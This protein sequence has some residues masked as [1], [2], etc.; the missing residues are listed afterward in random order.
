MKK[1]FTI[2]EILI[3]MMI[4]FISITFIN[5]SIQTFNNYQKK[6]KKYQNFYVTALSLKDWISEQPLD[7]K[8]YIGKL[9]DIN[10]II[11]VKQIIEERNYRFDPEQPSKSGN[12][13]DYLIILYKLTMILSE[14]TMIHEYNFYI[15]KQQLTKQYLNQKV[16]K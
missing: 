12:Y 16:E 9:N 7:Q 13:G 1:G 3:A 4:L 14:K 2:I 15:T 11:N 10:Y 8:K 5:I 6:S